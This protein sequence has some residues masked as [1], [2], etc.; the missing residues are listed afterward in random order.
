[1]FPPPAQLSRRLRAPPAPFPVPR[2]L[3]VACLPCWMS[4]ASAQLRRSFETPL[5]LCV[6]GFV[7]RYSCEQ[8]Q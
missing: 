2:S 6:R 4:L 5:A 1:M 7:L 8:S 3:A